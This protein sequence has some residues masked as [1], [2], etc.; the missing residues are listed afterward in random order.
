M[1]LSR[2]KYVNLEPEI[3]E[4]EEKVYRFLVENGGASEIELVA[5]LRMGR[6]EAW[7]YIRYFV[8]KGILQ[9]GESGG[10]HLLTGGGAA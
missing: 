1:E 2:E 7:Y 6:T 5:A 3:D 8:R 10:R 4:M 9:P